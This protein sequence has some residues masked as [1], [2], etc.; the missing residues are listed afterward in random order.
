[1]GQNLSAATAYAN[2]VNVPSAEEPSLLRV[3]PGDAA[4][5]YLYQKITGALG[6]VG[7]MM[8]LSGGPLSAND[9]ALIQQWINAG[10]PNN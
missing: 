8:P 2:I 6:I 3:K 7:S 1:M 4:H 5:S 10:A 9:M